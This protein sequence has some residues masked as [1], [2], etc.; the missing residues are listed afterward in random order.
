MTPGGAKHFRAEKLRAD[1][2]AKTNLGKSALPQEN[3][4][5]QYLVVLRGVKEP[6]EGEANGGRSLTLYFSHVLV[7]FISFLVTIFSNH[8]VTF[9]LLSCLSPLA[10]LSCG[11]AF[12]PQLDYKR[13]Y[14]SFELITI[15]HPDLGF[16]AKKARNPPK[17]KDS[18]SYLPNPSHP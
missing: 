7:P 16:L 4:E 17:N 1:F 3:T 18:L 5:D 9:W 10:S 11:I 12:G 13:F 14:M 8:C 15:T 2:S 6:Q